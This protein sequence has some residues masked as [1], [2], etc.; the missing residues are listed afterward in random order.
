MQKINN[1]NIMTF[2]PDPIRPSEG[3]EED[4]LRINPIEADK[5]GKEDQ[6]WGSEFEKR[7]PGVYG[8]FLVIIQK[9]TDLFDKGKGRS[10]L[11]EMSEDALTN[12]VQTLKQIFQLLMERDQSESGKFCAQFSAIWHRLLQGLQVFSHTKRKAIV[13]VEKLRILLMDIDNYPPNEDHKLGYY[14]SKFAGESW[15]PIPFRE[16]LKHL[17]TEHRMNEAHSTL[18]KWVEMTSEILQS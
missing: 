4:E 5:Q 2:F 1:G 12:D 10:G 6:A 15:L 16:I 9:L 7:R 11:E 8:A 17:Y 13:D 18:T 3:R 14:L